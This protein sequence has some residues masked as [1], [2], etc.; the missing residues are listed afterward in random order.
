MAATVLLISNGHGED[1]VAARLARALAEARPDIE[2][3]AFPTVG[4]GDA[5]AS[6]PVERAGPLRRLPSDGMTFRSPS[7][8]FADLRGGLVSTTVRQLRDLRALKPD[9]VIAVGD[10]WAE[11]LALV[12]RSRLRFCVQTLVSVR[13]DAGRPISTFRIFRERFTW[14]ER[15]LLRSAFRRAYLRDEDSAEA[16]RRSSVPSATYLGNPMVDELPD[17]TTVRRFARGDR[18]TF[19]LLPGTRGQAAAAL[20]TML[21]AVAAMEPLDAIVPW[22]QPTWP[23][24]PAGW[25][26]AERSTSRLILRRGETVVHLGTDT[27][28]EALA[29]ADVAIGTSGT[30]HEQAAALGIPVLAFRCGPGYTQS[31][32]EGQRR[33]LGDALETVAPDP[34]RIAIAATRLVNDPSE[35]SRRGEIGRSRMGGPG[36]SRAIAADVLRLATE[37]GA[38]E[39][40]SDR[41]GV[42]PGQVDS[43]TS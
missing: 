17:R 19:A 6:A 8:F 15:T 40:T 39:G 21:K 41:T 42:D 30:A 29:Q 2:L 18:P 26:E 43:A 34:D 32:L 23:D 37:A 13:M 3:I 14:F 27:F 5:F 10:V 35:L 28:A 36:A 12:P 20:H 16:L 22:T 38:I 4:R 33:L 7:L 31:F 24:V 25:T 11:A 1:A 9:L